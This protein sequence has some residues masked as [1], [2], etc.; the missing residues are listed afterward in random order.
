MKEIVYN[1]ILPGLGYLP[2]A[3]NTTE[4]AAM[5]FAIGMQESR[6]EHRFQIRGPARGFWQFE[7][8][9]IAG[10]LYHRATAELVEKV[11]RELVIKCTVEDCYEAVAYNDPLA[12]CF[13]RLLLWTLPDKLPAMNEHEEGWSM[14]LKGWRPGRPKEATWKSYYNVAWLSV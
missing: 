11:C 9:G 2:K 5:L 10:V 1:F 12:A 14:Y 3:M 13:A 6:F 8:N 7:K 4:A